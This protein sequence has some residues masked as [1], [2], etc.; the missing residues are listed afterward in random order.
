MSSAIQQVYPLAPAQAGILFH[1]LGA[2]GSGEY[3]VQISLRISGDIDPARE[4]LAW[5]ALVARHD[6]LRTAFVW[7]GQ[8][9]PLQVV[10]KTARPSV[11]IQDLSALDETAQQDAIQTYCETDRAQGFDL[12]AAPLLRVQR[13]DLGHG[14][15]HQ[16]VSFH[17][18]ILDGWSIPLLLRD[19]TALYAGRS[20]PEAKNFKDLLGWLHH[21]DAGAAR[22]FWAQELAGLDDIP[23]LTL[24]GPEMPQD[25]RG[26]CT[27]TLDQ[28]LTERLTQLAHAHRLTPST[29]VQ[30]LWAY[31]MARY[32]DSDEV[33]Y[34]LA[35]AGRPAELPGADT[36]VGMFLNTL[37]MRAKLED[38]TPLITWLS[39]LQQKYLAQ[40]PHAHAS[41]ADV[42]AAAAQPAGA[43][44]M[45]SVVVFENYPTD[46]ALLG[47]ADGLKVHDIAVTEQTNF[48][49]AFF[50]R[51]GRTLELKLL[52]D[53]R[54][55]AA[56]AATRALGH[57]QVLFRALA[58]DPNCLLAELSFMPQD[59]RARLLA[60]AV[61]V[62]A[63]PKFR[64]VSEAVSAHPPDAVA[65][66]ADKVLTYGA[67]NAAANRLAHQLI[68]KGVKAGDAIGVCL[69]RSAD[70]PVALL[71]ILRAKGCFVP[72]DPTYPTERLRHIADDSAIT[73]ILCQPKTARIARA[74]G[75]AALDVSDDLSAHPDT[76]PDHGIAGSDLAYLIYT[77]GSTGAPK[78]VP[79]PHTALNNLLHSF[80]KRLALS[81]QAKWLAVTTLSFDIATLEMFLPLCAGATLVIPQEGDIRDPVRLSAQITRHGI[82]HMQATP[83]TWRLLTESGW[84]GG[85]LT[86]LC[87]GE[88]LDAD[89]AQELLHKTKALWNVYG[90]TETTIWSTA[91]R[92][93]PH[94]LAGDQVPIGGA[95]ENTSLCVVDRCGRLT[96]QGLAGELCIGGKNLSPGYFRRDDLT[97]QRFFENDAGARLYRT[98][99]RVRWRAD[100]TLDYLG[101]L[102]T[103]AKIRGHR[104]EFG[105]IERTLTQHSDIEQA[106]VVIAGEHTSARLVAFLRSAADTAPSDHMMRAHLA[107]H[108]PAYMLPNSY[109]HLAEMPQTLNGKIDRNALVAKALAAHRT[110]MPLPT[111]FGEPHATLMGIWRDLL[112]VDRIAPQDSF[113]DL[114]GHSLLMVTLQDRIQQD[115]GAEVDI[116]DL[117]RFPTVQTQADHIAQ[118][119]AHSAPTPD[120]TR[121]ETRAL[122]RATGQTRL[123]QRRA[124]RTQQGPTNA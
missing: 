72:L 15:H 40:Q 124:I 38:A 96:P 42:Q 57:M 111:G 4:Q 67:L 11:Q 50:A 61:P 70:I 18:I 33:I 47:Q 10:G 25:R 105:E 95:L 74:L 60:R 51:L 44:L 29:L 26:E 3:L 85:N 97:A 27:L 22:Q 102:D 104:I 45:Q 99:D 110:A 49:L 101:R 98:G 73:T 23:H 28:N 37:P 6:V 55:I 24:P 58:D 71:A 13:F 65:V 16:I 20:L 79:I 108:L 59:E 48:P 119:L 7:K 39:A 9:Y 115:L 92:L 77:S 100:G 54:A 123:R 8:K 19:W 107:E 52:Y 116:T 86:A 91:L 112:G 121:I 21:Q 56:D 41:L 103:Q 31:L 75:C 5:A 120:T 94:H 118:I 46:P 122:A 14:R 82:T 76:R 113:F 114:G 36:R 64:S 69:H 81:A 106:V 66:H 34:G 53:G 109:V 83:S 78:G 43:T 17:H 84:E 30:G 62:P 35:R 89:L 87:G 80:Q 117:F 90:P 1:A 63:Q 68:S 32:N 12:H 88:A 93:E 2:P